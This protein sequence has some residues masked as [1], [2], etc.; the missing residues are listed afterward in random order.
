A[1][2]RG[3]P[4]PGRPGEHDPGGHEGRPRDGHRRGEVGRDAVDAVHPRHRRQAGLADRPIRP[5]ALPGRVRGAGEEARP[6][7][8]PA[9]PGPQKP[10][11]LVRAVPAKAGYEIRFPRVEGYTQAVRNRVA[12]DW[13]A[14]PPLTVDPLRI[15]PEVEVKAALPDNHGRPSLTGPGRLETVT[16]NPYRQGRRV[17]GLA[18]DLAASVTRAEADRPA[19]GLPPHVVFPQVLPIVRRYRAETHPAAL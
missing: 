4:Q 15:P 16:L 18:F 3:V 9:G 12:V 17:Q 5:G 8:P 13:D 2:G 7:D 6:G 14:L 19:C 10:R 11:H 1:E